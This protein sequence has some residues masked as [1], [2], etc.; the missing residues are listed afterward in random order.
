MQRHIINGLD[1]LSYA[2]IFLLWGTSVLVFAI[3]YVML[4]Y[5]AGN[6]LTGLQF[7]PSSTRVLDAIYFSVITATNTGY[8]DIVPLGLS[9]LFAATEAFTGLFLFALFMAKLV[10]RRQDIVIRHMHRLSFEGTFH[11][12]REDLHM[13]RGDFDR[14]IAAGREHSELAQHDWKLLTVAYEHATSIIRDIPHFYDDESNLYRIDARRELLLI[15]A[16]ERTLRRVET[17]LETLDASGIAWRD[18]PYSFDDLHKFIEM[19]E[20]VLPRWKNEVSARSHSFIDELS[21][22]VVRLRSLAART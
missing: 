12:V 6:E 8:G 13:I 10:S 3:I 17:M 11:D 14:I 5:S 9:R 1:K 2:T 21:Y 4:S 16:V 7:L 20:H 19:C 18:E 22:V 15:E